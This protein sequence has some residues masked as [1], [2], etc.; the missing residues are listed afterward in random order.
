MSILCPAKAICEKPYPCRYL[1]LV[2]RIA[3]SSK[4]AIDKEAVSSQW[5]SVALLH[6]TYIR[7][8][9][10][11]CSRDRGPEPVGVLLKV[12]DHDAGGGVRACVAGGVAG[13][14]SVEEVAGARV[15]SVLG[16][17][18]GEPRWSPAPILESGATEPQGEVKQVMLR[19]I[20]RSRFTFAS[21]HV[22]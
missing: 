13:V 19:S 11:R 5:Q 3:C 12:G 18:L 21:R 15:L 16:Q 8:H 1:I 17:R 9:A 20:G 10:P 14:V 22:K 6:C 7:T 2:I 4:L